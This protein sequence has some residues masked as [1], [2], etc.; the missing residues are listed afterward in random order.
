MLK[1]AVYNQEG[2]EIERIDLDPKVFD[3]EPNLA[4]LH[5]V[6]NTYLA[7]RRKGSASTKN[8][9]EVSGGGRKPWR[10]KGTGRARIG[11][12]RSPVWRHGGV[13]FG[14]KPRD[15]HK[16]IPKKVKILALRSSLISKL[17]DDDLVILEDIKL[18]RPKTKEMKK[19]L[20]NLKIKEKSLLLVDKLEPNLKL[21]SS[22][23]KDLCLLT[24]SNVN[25]YDILRFKKVILTKPALEQILK[26]IS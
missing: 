1:S 19:I 23:L 12:I 15:F 24:V 16:K 21:G 8:R 22:N 6:I 17:K 3:R 26:R 13:A 4:V 18:E 7:N 9:A 20:D 14:P 2:K 10:Q 5:Q 25:A 11:S